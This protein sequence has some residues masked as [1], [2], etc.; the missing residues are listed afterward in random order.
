MPHDPP[1]AIG[2]LV[3]D[4]LD[5]IDLAGPFEVLSRLP[6][7]S[8][9][10]YARRVLSVSEPP[11]IFSHMSTLSSTFVTHAAE[12]VLLGEAINQGFSEPETSLRESGV[13]RRACW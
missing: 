5:Q 6:G 9:R 10:L 4:D 3:F 7:A 11:H 2:S 12:L 8:H 1:L 13:S